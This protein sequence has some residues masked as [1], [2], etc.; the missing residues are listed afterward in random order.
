MK[1]PYAENMPYW[2]SGQ[3]SPGTWLDKAGDLIEKR[4]GIVTMKAEG[5]YNDRSG[6]MIDFKFDSQKFRIIW[7]VLPTKG[8]NVGVAARRQAATMI[9]HDVKGRIN[10][11]LILGPRA[12]FFE[13]QLLPDG[14]TVGQLS[15]QA[16]IDY[17]PQQ[18]LQ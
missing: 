12:A 6:F 13:F 5:R 10:R 2:K 1:L 9:Y 17:V 3:S 14:R 15:N 18:L 7:P 16:L 11:L 8:K 4:G